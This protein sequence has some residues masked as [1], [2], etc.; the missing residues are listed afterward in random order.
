VTKFLG[1]AL[2][3]FALAI[4]VV[5]FFTDCQSQGKALTLANGTSV[6]M[7]CHWTGLAEIATSVPLIVVGAMMVAN[8]RKENLLNLGI[9]G[10][11]LGILVILL[12]TN[13]I[14]V[15]QSA[16]LCNTAMKP[17]LIVL[18]SLAIVASLAAIVLAR[19]TND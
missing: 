15:C 4:A 13:L 16:M 17:A 1:I 6:P 12:P 2:I 3:I 11:I 7:K 9:L 14:G 19:K 5:P 8:R 10:S 18:G